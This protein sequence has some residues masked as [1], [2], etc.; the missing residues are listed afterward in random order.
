MRGLKTSFFMKLL[1]L[2]PLLL[3]FSVPAIAHNE[4]NG[5]EG[6]HRGHDGGELYSSEGEEGEG[7][8]TEEGEDSG[9]G[10]SNR[11]GII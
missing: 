10:K 11:I 3:G 8:E 6:G 5:G 7:A 2:L 9:D 1:F 4:F